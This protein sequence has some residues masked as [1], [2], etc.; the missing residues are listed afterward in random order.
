MVSQKSKNK[1]KLSSKSRLL[2]FSLMELI[3]VIAVIAIVAVLLTPSFVSY[4]EMSR[5]QKDVTAL[6]EVNNAV[7]TGL[8]NVDVLDELHMYSRYNNVSCYIDSNSEIGLNKHITSRPSEEYEQYTFGDETRQANKVIYA[9]AGH[10]YGVTVTFHPSGEQN[11]RVYVIGDGVINEYVNGG[12]NVKLSDCDALYLVIKQT[13]GDTISLSSQ[14]YKNS[15]YTIFIRMSFAHSGDVF[16]QDAVSVYGQYCGT[17]LHKS[18]HVHQIA[19]NRYV[20]DSVGGNNCNHSVVIVNGTDPTCGEPGLTS[21]KYCSICSEVFKKQGVIPATG[22][23]TWRVSEDMKTRTC[24]VCGKT[25]DIGASHTHSY[26]TE[27]TAGT[28]ITIGKTVYNCACGYS[29]TMYNIPLDPNNHEG[30]PTKTLAKEKECLGWTCC[31]AIYSSEH[32]M[33]GSTCTVCGYNSMSDHEHKYVLQS[34]I[35]RYLASAA[36]CQAPAKYYKHCACGE[37]GS[38]TFNYGSKD[39]SNHVG[40]QTEKLTQPDKCLGYTCCPHVYTTKHN[41]VNGKCSLCDYEEAH[42]HDFKEVVDDRYLVDGA[43]CQS[44]ATYYYSC[45]CGVADTMTFKAGD[46]DPNN[47]V[48]K[49]ELKIAKPDECLAYTCCPHVYTTKHQMV[50]GQCELCGYSPQHIHVYSFERAEEPYLNSPA[51]CTAKA[52]YF[53]SCEC[54]A[55]SDS[56]TFEFGDFDLN[57]HTGYEVYGGTQDVHTKWNCCETTISS[58]HTYTNDFNWNSSCSSVTVTKT[59]VCRYQYVAETLRGSRIKER[60]LKTANCVDEGSC[61]HY[62]VYEGKTDYCPYTHDTP[63]D[64]T[65]HKGK[66]IEINTKPTCV[67]AGYNGWECEAC[68]VGDGVLVTEGAEHVGGFRD[69]TVVPA[70]CVSTGTNREICEACGNPTGKT[71]EDPINPNNHPNDRRME[72]DVLATCVATGKDKEICNACNNPTGKKQDTLKNPNNHAGGFE[73]VTTKVA[74]CNN[75]GAWAQLCKACSKYTGTTGT[76]DKD[77][78]NH[79]GPYTEKETKAA[80]CVSMGE[81]TKTCDACGY[82]AER[83]STSKNKDNHPTGEYSIT[84][85]PTCLDKGKKTTYCAHCNAKKKTEELA[86]LGH[87]IKS[88]TQ[89][90]PG[91]QMGHGHTHTCHHCELTWTCQSIY[92]SS[93]GY[94]ENPRADAESG[95]G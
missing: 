50:D 79:V 29:N 81:K 73:N 82:V 90:N 43:T 69:E 93:A 39:S 47:H 16:E 56:E 45:A 9:L 21:G 48:G 75:P 80:T 20:N 22:N 7:I 58:D 26:T 36:N 88:T 63:T 14:T 8:T 10:M 4:V 76:T 5:A 52:K 28:C 46:V 91:T 41:M 44:A 57:N 95:A 37:A 78:A 94:K 92:C 72:P 19:G 65:N 66:I 59:C 86:A 49:L 55:A 31:G 54:K 11:N 61:D 70:T 38:E 77:T 71:G 35:A 13:L 89:N 17:S 15:E 68:G 62:V 24:I 25:E 85:S 83:I 87:R 51:T 32:T 27:I 74:T 12:S 23:H 33:D 84:D 42:V 60:T 34:V 53:L 6:E 1:T 18:A 3:V 30:E 2:G 64:S 40:T 67:S